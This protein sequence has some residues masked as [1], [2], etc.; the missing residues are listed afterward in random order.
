MSESSGEKTEQ[1]TDKKLRDARQR[2]Q[3]AK[4]TDVTTTIVTV[5]VLAATAGLFHLTVKSFQ[6]LFTAGL[7][8]LNDEPAA[9]FS[10]MTA[11]SLQTLLSVILPLA[12]ACIVG[13]LAGSYLQVG[14]MFAFE[15]MKP[16]LNKL[17]PLEGVK[18]IFSLKNL[19]E[20]VKSLLKV[21]VLSLLLYFIIKD[22]IDPLMQLPLTDIQ[23]VPDVFE[24]MFLWFILPFMGVYLV[25]AAADYFLQRF[26]FIRE[27]KMTKDEVKREYKQQEGS[28]EI[29]GQR[30][31]LHREMINEDTVGKTK[32]A[33]V[34]IT[35]PTHYAVGLY[36]EPGITKL[37]KVTVKG[38]DSLAFRM[39]DVA[40]DNQV[41]VVQNARIARHL[42][43]NVKL[44]D[45]IP[46]EMLAP[47][48]EI[49]KW[50][51][52]LPKRQ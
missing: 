51:Q 52:T 34:L 35:N 39:I 40:K 3:V 41:P 31:S 29:K 33:T 5:F 2:G 49:L 19:M 14:V 46:N 48:A 11:K 4:S 37:P 50:V 15:A 38:V 13:V 26:L 22:S 45:F 9:A 24:K 32:S 8:V 25:V 12:L 44:D 42:Y 43:D 6:E 28:P 21:S 27:M 47:I 30:K 16:D 23:A 7:A 36:Y 1:P 20:F 18:K 17:N 10:L